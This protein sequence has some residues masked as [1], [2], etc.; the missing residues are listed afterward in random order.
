MRPLGGAV[1]GS[2]LIYPSL[3]AQASTELLEAFP[4]TP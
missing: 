3:V 4:D 2:V 1:R